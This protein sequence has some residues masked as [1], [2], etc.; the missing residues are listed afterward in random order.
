MGPRLAL[1]EGAGLGSQA[2]KPRSRGSPEAG[3][4]ASLVL[5][6][7]ADAG[8]GGQRLR[9]GSPFQ[10]DR[11][12]ARRCKSS[13]GLFTPQS[14]NSA[15]AERR[16]RSFPPKPLASLREGKACPLPNPG[17]REGRLSGGPHWP[18]ECRD[19]KT[20]FHATPLLK[21][22][23][24]LRPHSIP[25]R[26]AVTQKCEE[27]GTIIHCWWDHTLVQPRKQFGGSPT[28][29]AQNRHMTQHSR[30]GSRPRRL[31]HRDS[32]QSRHIH[33]HGSIFHDGQML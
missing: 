13:P 27:T 10:G 8:A 4:A 3:G 7:K 1:V 9:G 16:H 28:A 14:R 25:T 19:P 18:Q 24:I 21:N 30:P 6:G 31:E 17:T 5:W 12:E 15:T 29:E 33:A 32:N 26:A 20:I 11:G 2:E 23:S 22:E